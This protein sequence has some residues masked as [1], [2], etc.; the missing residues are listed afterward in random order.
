MSNICKSTLFIWI[1]FMISSC[2]YKSKYENALLDIKKNSIYEKLYEEQK[3]FTYLLQDSLDN[4]KKEL[5]TVLFN[6]ERGLGDDSGADTIMSEQEMELMEEITRLR[7]KNKMLLQSIAQLDSQLL[8]YQ[9]NVDLPEEVQV[10]S[11]SYIS[12][13]VHLIN[14]FRS[15]QAEY[16]DETFLFLENDEVAFSID[17]KVLFEDTYTLSPVGIEIVRQI[18]QAMN[19]LFGH[20]MSIGSKF[21]I[22]DPYGEDWKEAIQ[23]QIMIAQLMKRFG[24]NQ[25]R[26][27]G[28][29]AFIQGSNLDGSYMFILKE[30]GFV[31]P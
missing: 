21:A 20:E 4:Y 1:I 12:K 19:P 29:N 3:E 25:D 15:I 22:D 13:K 27:D 26:I 17:R 30:R 7:N 18:T 31:V 9:A 16:P 6:Y 24:I 23:G 28:E 14:T 11:H 5:S 10:R 2:S 8:I